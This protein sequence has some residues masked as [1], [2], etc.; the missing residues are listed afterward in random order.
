MSVHR[1]ERVPCEELQGDFA[2]YEGDIYV[3]QSS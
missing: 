2:S 3:I 1:Q